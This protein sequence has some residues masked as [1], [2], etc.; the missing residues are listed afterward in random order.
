VLS[1]SYKLRRLVRAFTR[2][3]AQNVLTRR[4]LEMLCHAPWRELVIKELGGMRKLKL[5]EAARERIMARASRAP[6]P[7][8]PQEPA[9]LF[10][11]ERIAESER[12]KAWARDCA[13]AAAPKGFVRDKV[14]MDCD[15]EFRLAPLPRGAN[16][17]RQIRV[18]TALSISDYDWDGIPFDTENGFGPISV[19]PVEFYAAMEIEAGILEESC[20]SSVIPAKEPENRFDGE[21]APEGS[22]FRVP[23]CSP[24]M[25]RGEN[26][27]IRS[28][29]DALSPKLRAQIFCGIPF[30]PKPPGEA[31]PVQS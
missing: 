31:P 19:W 27:P 22:T 15:G 14:K 18:Y 30:I 3:E 4:K 25:T 17:A 13:R 29:Y 21:P 20:I 11:P 10:T 8:A 12:L 5:W 7:P 2:F 9:W 24:G 28:A 23:P 16:A 26:I 1:Y 6:K